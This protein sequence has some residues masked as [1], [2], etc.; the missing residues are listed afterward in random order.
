MERQWLKLSARGQV[1]KAEL[2][3]NRSS[4]PGIDGKNLFTTAFIPL[5]LGPSTLISKG[6]GG[7]FLTW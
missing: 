1:A 2:P 5:A 6:W 3:E 4:I 7:H